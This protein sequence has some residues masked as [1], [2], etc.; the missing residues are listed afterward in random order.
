MVVAPGVSVMKRFAKVD[1]G[2]T[3]MPAVVAFATSAADNG[4]NILRP[5]NLS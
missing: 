1:S 2:D 4:M 3:T 5:V